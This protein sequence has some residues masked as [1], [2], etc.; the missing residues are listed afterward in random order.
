MRTCIYCGVSRPDRFPREHVIPYAFGSFRNALTLGCVCRDCNRYFGSKL[1]TQFA[2][3]SAES[4]ARF[5]HGLRDIESAERTRTIRAKANV[6]GPILGAKVRLHPDASVTSGIGN[7]FETQVAFKNKDEQDWRWYTLSELT[8]ETVQTLEPGAGIKLLPISEPAAAGDEEAIASKLREEEEKIRS[9][10]RELGFASQT[11]QVSRDRVLPRKDLITRVTCDFTFDMSRCVAKIAFNYLAY[12]L[13]E[14]AALLLREEFDTVR[15]YVRDGTVA[16]EPVVYFSQT[17]KF[18]Q[19][20]ET[21]PFVDGHVVSVGWD[22]PNENIGCLLS[23]FNTM[24]YRVMLSRNCKG[25]WF[26]PTAHSFDLQTGEVRSI[27]ISLLPR[28]IL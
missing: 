2:R 27:P 22:S 26:P 7:V 9:R 28:P 24:S 8:S 10:L 18:E 4:I 23:L 15:K 5:R 19:D 25:V 6:P 16:E 3:E 21:A 13:G 14:N 17:P 12:V 11:V 20:A 1:E